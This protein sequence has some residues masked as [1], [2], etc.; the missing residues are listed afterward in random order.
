[1]SEPS[2]FDKHSEPGTCGK[3]GERADRHD[4]MVVRPTKGVA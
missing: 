3:H 2:E 1:M 4:T